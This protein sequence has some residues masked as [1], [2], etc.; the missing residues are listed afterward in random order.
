MVHG[1]SGGLPKRLLLDLPRVAKVRNGC[2]M[3]RI[4]CRQ[5]VGGPK[6]LRRDGSERRWR[7]PCKG[8]K[9]CVTSLSRPCGPAGRRRRIRRPDHA[10]SLLSCGDRNV[11][12]CRRASGRG[13]NNRQRIHRGSAVRGCWHRVDEAAD[14]HVWLRRLQGSKVWFLTSARG[15]QVVKLMAEI[16]ST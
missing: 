9:V 5:R 7:C 4:V 1:G 12:R 6:V 11:Q 13:L 16:V 14:V 15:V 2:I 8:S 10:L 3:R